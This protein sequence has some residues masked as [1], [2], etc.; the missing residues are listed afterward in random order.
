MACRMLKHCYSNEQRL[1]SSFDHP[2]SEL[3]RAPNSFTGL[4]N[5]IRRFPA[6]VKAL[7]SGSNI[8]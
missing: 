2:C 5:Q 6:S 4:L 3:L 1:D 8:S 7:E